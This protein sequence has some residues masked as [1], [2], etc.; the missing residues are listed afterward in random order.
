MRI[1]R[2]QVLAWGVH[3][4]TA[5]GIVMAFM[6]IQAIFAQHWQAAFAWMALTVIVDSVDGTLARRL[7]VKGVLPHFDGALL[8]NIIDYQTYVLLPALMVYEAQLVPAGWSIVIASLILLASAYQFSQADAKTEDHFFKGF[9]SYWNV[10][11]F[12]LFMLNLNGWINLLALLLCTVLVFVP[13][14][15]IYPS[16][17]ARFKRLTLILSGFWGL[18]VLFTVVEYPD[19]RPWLVYGSLAFVLYYVLLSAYLTKRPSLARS[20]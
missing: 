9:P 4:F 20:R 19:F 11:V 17:T 3:A 14:K 18:A 13:I 5:S 12:Y 7:G 2:K 15:Y 6:A 1:Q 8:D 10:A 16:R